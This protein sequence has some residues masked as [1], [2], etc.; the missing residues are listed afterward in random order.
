MTVNLGFV[1]FAVDSEL[2]GIVPK[3]I[4][5]LGNCVASSV[6]LF[7]QT[8]HKEYTA[9]IYET[10]MPVTDGF[11]F[12]KTLQKSTNTTPSVVSTVTEA[13]TTYRNFGG[14]LT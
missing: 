12:L 2:S 11:E 4:F 8:I 10:Q 7:E 3:S 5:M 13:K 1:P 14:D 9:N 6:F